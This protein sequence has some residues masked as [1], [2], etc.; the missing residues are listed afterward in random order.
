MLVEPPFNLL[1]PVS[2]VS[3]NPDTARTIAATAPAVDRGERNTEEHGELVRSQQP[4][5]VDRLRG[6]RP[7]RDFVTFDA[8]HLLDCHRDVEHPPNNSR[9]HSRNGPRITPGTLFLRA[10]RSGWRDSLT[11]HIP[12]G[13]RQRHLQI[14]PERLRNVSRHPAPRPR[15]LQPPGPT[16]R[17]ARPLRP[18]GPAWPRRAPPTTSTSTISTQTHF[19]SPHGGDEGERSGSDPSARGC[20]T[21]GTC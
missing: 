8:S 12:P 13:D 15:S 20:G 9:D 7:P 18:H 6:L 1:D 10:G 2:H 17:A 5:T 4:S 19:S 16:G 14:H 11:S 21:A 3:A